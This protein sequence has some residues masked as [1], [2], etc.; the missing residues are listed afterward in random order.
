MIVLFFKRPTCHFFNLKKSS[1]E[2]GTVSNMKSFNY[3]PTSTSRLLTNLPE[4]FSPHGFGLKLKDN[5]TSKFA[6]PKDVD[7]MQT[8]P[9]SRQSP[10]SKC[11]ATL[12]AIV[13]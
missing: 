1:K 12:A 6:L 4:T 9:I 3:F 11:A 8:K 10:I 13:V 2:K 5:Q 7:S